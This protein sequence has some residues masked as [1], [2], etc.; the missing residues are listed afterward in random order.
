MKIFKSNSTIFQPYLKSFDSFNEKFS[1]LLNEELKIPT[2]KLTL[3]SP[4]E[5]ILEFLLPLG[6]LINHYEERNAITH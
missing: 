6:T 2:I 1:N 3:D 4:L 5:K